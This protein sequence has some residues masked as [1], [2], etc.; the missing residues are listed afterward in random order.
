MVGATRHERLDERPRM[1]VFLPPAGAVRVDDLVARTA[2]I[3][4]ALIEPVQGAIW[5]VD[6][7]QTFYR[8]AT[9]DELVGI[10]WS[11]R[12]FALIVLTGFAALALLL[13]AA[14]L[15][16]VL[17]RIASRVAGEIGVRVALGRAGSTSCDWCSAAGFAVAASASWC[18]SGRSA[19]RGC[20]RV[21]VQRRARRSGRDRRRRGPDAA[22]RGAGLL[23]PRGAPRRRIPPTCCGP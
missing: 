3:R 19:A 11:P 8:T 9:L 1:E 16:G 7:L 4:H 13:A 17:R 21:S 10:R 5:S 18:W 23:H 14:G 22:R 12:R 15:Y 6:P 20:S 2:S